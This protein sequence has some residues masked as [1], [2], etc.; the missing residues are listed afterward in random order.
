M[1]SGQGIDMNNL[2][3]INS[4]PSLLQEMDGE[5]YFCPAK[6]LYRSLDWRISDPLQ[7][8][9]GLNKERKIQNQELKALF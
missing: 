8:V 1:L 9:I 7:R 5:F 3:L 6:A 4:P 2:L